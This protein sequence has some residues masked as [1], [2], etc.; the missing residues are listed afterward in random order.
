MRQYWKVKSEN[1]KHMSNFLSSN[2]IENWSKWQDIFVDNYIFVGIDDFK[3]GWMKYEAKSI[4]WYINNKY[5]Y[6]GEFNPLK[7]DRINKLN[8]INNSLL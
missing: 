6:L 1:I 7:R 4:L 3:S 8:K 2:Q 5:K